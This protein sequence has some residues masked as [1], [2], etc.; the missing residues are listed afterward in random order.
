MN[1]FNVGRQCQN[2]GTFGVRFGRG[3]QVT[4]R[5]SPA[6]SVVPALPGRGLTARILF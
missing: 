6:R 3:V 2:F 1:R 5:P 4:S